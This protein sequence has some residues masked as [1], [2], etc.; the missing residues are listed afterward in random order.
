[1]VSESSIPISEMTTPPPSPRAMT[2]IST[3]LTEDLKNYYLGE[4]HAMRAYHYFHL[5]RSWGDVILYLDYTEGQ[6]IDLSNITKPVSP[7]TA[8]MEQIKKDIEDSEKAFGDNY[9]FKLGRHYWSMAA[10]QMLKGEVYLWSGSQ[11]G[12]GETDYR[13]AKQAFENVKKADVALVGNFKDVFS[14]TNKKNKE[15][16]FTIH[17]GKDE[18]SL[19]GGGYVSKKFFKKLHFLIRP[20]KSIYFV[21]YRVVNP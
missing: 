3:V 8:V 12:G 19:W 13:I 16:I 7:A 4:A 9:S 1:M 14:Y 18:Y 15:M 21:Q 17:N 6:N 2:T 5:L 10:T 20:N 11:M